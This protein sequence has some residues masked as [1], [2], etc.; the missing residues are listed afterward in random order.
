MRTPAR[1]R[2]FALIAL[3]AAI[4]AAGCTSGAGGGDKAGGAGEPVVLTMASGYDQRTLEVEPAVASFVQQVG[5][6]SGG[7]VR[8]HL[9][10]GWGDYQPGFEQ[11]IVRDVRTD[12]AD[13]AWVGT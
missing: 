6:L 8:I 13:L 4:V 7:E 3:V 5:E 1:L 11:Q 10:D 12:K 2:T 9:V